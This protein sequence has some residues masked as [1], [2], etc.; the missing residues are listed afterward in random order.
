MEAFIGIAHQ[1]D[2]YKYAIETR[3]GEIIYKAD[4][5]AFYSQKR[6]QHGLRHMGS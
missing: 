4:P 3:M 5:F 2:T 1:G 6:A